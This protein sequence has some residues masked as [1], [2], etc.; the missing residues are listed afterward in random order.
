VQAQKNIRNKT[1][2]ET[3]EKHRTSK[4]DAEI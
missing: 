4:T 2:S 1:V 3:E